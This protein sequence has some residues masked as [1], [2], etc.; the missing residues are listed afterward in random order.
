MPWSRDFTAWLANESVNFPTLEG[1]FS[2]FTSRTISFK[3]KPKEWQISFS[4]TMQALVAVGACYL[5]TIL[6]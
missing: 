1:T 4:Q 6:T 2:R 5:D 3:P